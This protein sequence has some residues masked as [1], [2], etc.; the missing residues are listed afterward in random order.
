MRRSSNPNLLILEMTV[1]DLGDLVNEFVF[2]GRCATGLLI[3]DV[4]A[5]PIRETVDVDV[6]VQ[7]LS[8]AEYYA[9]SDRL[10][11]AGFKA[12]IRD[13]APICRWTNGRV[14]LDVMPT[15]P[16]ILGFGNEW[17]AAAM[18][19]AQVF[20]LPSGK[21]IL[22]VS[23]PYFLITKLEAFAG[24]GAGDYQLS[25]D[26]EDIVAVLDGRPL[27]ADEVEQAEATLRAALAKRFQEL[28][29]DYRFTDS[30]SG[31]LPADAV[32]QA[33]TPIVLDRIKKIAGIQ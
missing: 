18:A 20:E 28:L 12:D 19:H 8:K 33:R 21:S 9:L 30:I 1:N 5:P 16:A 10:R 17:Y 24:R 26:L 13:G 14:L 25:H 29:S 22:L 3:V 32:S 6:I 11:D 27:V 23:S 31:H 2:L 4:A 15:D 7:V